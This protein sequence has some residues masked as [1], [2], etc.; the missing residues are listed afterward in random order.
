MMLIVKVIMTKIIVRPVGWIPELA[1]KLSIHIDTDI[2]I[3]A[4]KNSNVVVNS[5][6]I[7]LRTIRMLSEKP[8]FHHCMSVGYGALS[9]EICLFRIL[10]WVTGL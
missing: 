8:K 6:D 1:S 2:D 10:Y 9:I 3:A 5:V 7:I 4:L